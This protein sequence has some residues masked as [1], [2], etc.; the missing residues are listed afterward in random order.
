M[1]VIAALDRLHSDS[2]L[3]SGV[4]HH[5]V[6]PARLAGYAPVSPPLND[7]VA[8]GLKRLGL[9]RL[10]VHQA[11]A[12]SAARRGDDLV[13][14]TPTASGKTLCYALPILE[15]SMIQPDSR[16]LLVYP[17]K[18]LAHDQMDELAT[19]AEA[20]GAPARVLAYDGD[21]P[22]ALRADIRRRASL[23]VTNPDML[24]VSILPHHPQWREMLSRLDYIVIDELHSYR[25]VFGA[26]VANVMRRLQRICR[27][28]GSRPQIISTSA[29]IANPVE[30]T[31]MLTERQ[32]MLVDE[33][34]APNGR[35]HIVLYNP[36]LLDAH[37]GIRRSA[38]AD[39]RL[40]ANLLQQLDLQTVVFCQS[41]GGVEQL[42]LELRQDAVQAGHA[43]DSV[44]GYRGGYLDSERREIE[45]GLRA[46]QVRVV[47]ATN[48]LEL[49]VDIGGM[50][51]AVLVGYPGS[52]A[53]TWQRI[54]RAGRGSDDSLAVLVATASPLDQYI[55]THPDY[56]FAQAPERGLANPDN[57]HVLLSHVRCASYELPFAADEVY[58]HED[59]QAVLAHLEML[60]EL[61]RSR[62]R[63]H[64]I[65]GDYPAG[66][67][68]L[69]S[70]SPERITILKQGIDGEQV[71]GTVDRETAPL[72][73]HEQAIYLHEGQQY[74]VDRL[75]WPT[76]TAHVHAVSVDYFTR[77]SGNT[78]VQILDTRREEAH[79]GYVL[80]RGEIELTR[81][82]TGFRRLRQRTLEMI[83]WGEIDLPEQTIQT[84][85]MWLTLSEELVAGLSDAASWIGEG[86]FSRGP[87]WPQQR[88]SVLERDGY[89]CR[90]CGAKARPGQGLHVH[91]L[92]PYS[93]YGQG[94]DSPWQTANDLSNL[95]T[96]C[97]SCHRRA[98]QSVAVRGSLAGLGHALRHLL[99]T[100][101]LCDPGDVSVVSEPRTVQTGLATLFVYDDLPGGVGL[102]FEAMDA[103]GPLIG[104]V[105][106]LVEGCACT[107]GC[108]SC[109]GPVLADDLGAKGR[110][111]ALAER[112]IEG[113]S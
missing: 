75:D 99:P 90:W 39:A 27:F 20:V 101:L 93:T 57:L 24:H 23:L 54:G 11:Q 76:G 50:A 31:A 113:L 108:P 98:E 25:G 2:A 66:E 87:D 30:L 41:R 82:V 107:S 15:R 43:A 89:A 51:A 83:G 56:L 69:R 12:L 38:M 48:A 104:R 97:P 79:R 16:A 4:V 100:L 44:R 37:L 55:V 6:A 49:G 74:L 40:I 112:L 111:L 102:S 32:P 78:T 92:R 77:A 22:M 64:R 18:A 14:V 73:V 96:L 1:S 8:A 36:P 94:D 10:Y 71:I 34:G 105:L 7:P 86:S 59:V 28:Y 45:Q 106:E 33:N 109:I 84:E 60:G 88:H 81:R 46:G 19:L 80:Q 65:A 68:S 52:V 42:L 91:H 110:V 95:V 13:V 26:H 9:E 67:V 61:R 3:A 58:G 53:S 21:T 63:W 85:A 72:Y 5:R 29:T 62:V 17:N 47:V 70:A 35:R 103:F